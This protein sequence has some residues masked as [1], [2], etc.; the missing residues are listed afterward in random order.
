MEQYPRDLLREKIEVTGGR[1]KGP[2]QGDFEPLLLRPCRLIGDIEALL[3]DSVD[4][5]GSILAGTLPRMQ[6]HVLHDCICALAVLHDLF[7]I[8]PQR[9][10]LISCAIPAVNGPSEA[11]FSVWRSRSC[12][13]RK[14]S[15]DWGRSVRWRNSLSSLVFSMAITASSAKSCSNPR[16]LSV[17]WRSSRR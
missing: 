6:E 4:V 3:D 16:G 15:N 10:F 7:E 5:D 11:S 13:I 8:I 1:V 14:C 2:F 17:K 12:V 9:G